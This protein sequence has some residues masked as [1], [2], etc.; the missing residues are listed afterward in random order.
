ML[1]CSS[2]K[3]FMPVQRTRYHASSSSHN[4]PAWFSTRRDFK[5]WFII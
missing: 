2:D 1:Y 5:N 3:L 4:A